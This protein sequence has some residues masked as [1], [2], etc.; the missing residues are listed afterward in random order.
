[1]VDLLSV[2]DGLRSV[3]EDTQ[4]GEVFLQLM[5][6]T[7]H[8]GIRQAGRNRWHSLCPPRQRRLA[9]PEDVEEGLH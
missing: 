5:Q 6:E 3:E 1:M 8:F 7:G 9:A 2:F 4:L